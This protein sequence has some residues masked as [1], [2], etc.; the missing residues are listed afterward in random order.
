MAAEDIEDTKEDP[1]RTDFGFWHRYAS[2]K[3]DENSE[4]TM[5]QTKTRMS[6]T[7]T[8]QMIMTMIMKQQPKKYV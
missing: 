8:S 7:I 2:R 5:D 3:S 6:M 4:E 1:L